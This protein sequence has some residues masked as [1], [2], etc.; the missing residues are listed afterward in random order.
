MYAIP[1]VRFRTVKCPEMDTFFLCLI[2]LSMSYGFGTILAIYNV[3][4]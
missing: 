3:N 2:W 1:S 4:F